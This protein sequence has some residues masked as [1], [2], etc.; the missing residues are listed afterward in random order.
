MILWPVKVHYHLA[1]FFGHRPFGSRDIMVSICHVIL[2][3]HVIKTLHNFM[4]TSP[5]R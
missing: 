3:D 2:Q 5:L 4:V 1:K